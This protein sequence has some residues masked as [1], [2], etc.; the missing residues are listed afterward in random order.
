MH[1]ITHIC[2]SNFFCEGFSY[3]ENLLTRFHRKMGYEVD[4]IASRQS[5]DGDGR[6]CLLPGTE[7]YVNADGVHVV[8]L[9]Y[10]RPKRAGRLLRKYRGFMEALEESAPDVLFVHGVQSAENAALVR[11]VRA[12]SGTRMFMDNHADYGNSATNWLSRHVLHRVV[13]RHYAR[14]AEPYVER[15]WGVLPARVDFL[16]ENY[17]LPPGKCSLLVMGADDEEVAR[18]SDPSVRRETRRRFGFTDDDFVVVTGGKIDRNKPEVLNLMRS[19]IELGLESVRL[20]VFGPVVPELKDEF[21]ELLGRGAI[22]HVP[23]ANPSDSYDY[24]ASADLVAFPGKHSVYWEQ[25]AALGVPLL[26]RR[27]PGID[28][29]ARRDAECLEDGT[30]S[31]IKSALGKLVPLWLRNERLRRQIAESPSDFLYSKIAEKSINLSK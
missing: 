6:P 1:K 20:L 29:I 4:V 21:D 11:Y 7:D 2:L 16:V 30:V 19:V 24:F 31:S 9:D 5:F 23:W 8:R 12:H 14:L 15:F 28:H 22:S 18:A 17:G 26:L 3:Q 27:W 13:W 10:A 25:A